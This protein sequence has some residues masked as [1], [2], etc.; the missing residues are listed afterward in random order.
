MWPYN[1]SHTPIKTHTIFFQVADAYEV[2]PLLKIRMT[3]MKRFVIEGPKEIALRGPDVDAEEEKC[4]EA[5][6]SERQRDMVTSTNRTNPLNYFFLARRSS[7][8]TR[9]TPL[10]WPC[11]PERDA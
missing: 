6:V 4:K 10:T 3:Q 2:N 9:F 1:F 5:E 7:R 8:S 11:P